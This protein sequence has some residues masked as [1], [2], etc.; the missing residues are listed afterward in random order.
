MNRIETGF[1]RRMKDGE[2]K[3]YSGARFENTGVKDD[4]G[5]VIWRKLRKDGQPSNIFAEQFRPDA[6]WV[7]GKWFFMLDAGMI[8]EEHPE[9]KQPTEKALSMSHEDYCRA[10]SEKYNKDF[11]IPY[12]IG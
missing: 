9:L 1:F 4:L 6:P 2:I 12:T 3:N 5:K 10:L 11:E 8:L 7:S